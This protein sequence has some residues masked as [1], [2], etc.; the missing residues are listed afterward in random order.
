MYIISLYNRFRGYLKNASLYFISSLASALIGVLLNPLL[1]LNLSPED[2]AILGYYSSFTLLV[3]PLLH[4]CLLSYYSRQYYFIDEN[5]REQLGNTILLS[6]N[7]IGFISLLIFLLL[8]YGFCRITNVEFAFM[9]YAVLTFAQVYISNNLTFYL[10]QLRIQRKAG[11]Y[12][13]VSIANCII[14]NI[15][16]IIFVVVFKGGA[17]GKL[18]AALIASLLVAC[19]SFYK[20]LTKWQLDQHLLKD[21]LNFGLPLTFSALFWYCLSGVDRLFLERLGDISS[22][23][24]Y[25]VAIS[26]AAYMQLIFN[27]LNSTFEPDI[28][29]A[30]AQQNKKKL[31]LIITVILLAVIVSN[32]VFILF[33][34]F[35]VNLLTAGRYIDSVPY[36]RILAIS[37]ITMACYYMVVKLIIGN[38]FVKGELAVRIIGSVLSVLM[39]YFIIKYNGYIGASWGQVISF[40][41]LSIIGILFLFIKM[42]RGR[43]KK[44]ENIDIKV[45]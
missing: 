26:I 17:Q 13:K 15:L 16:I 43:H 2:Y 28:Y 22:L 45:L 27:T 29:Q 4:C 12:A 41:L 31:F 20:S 19:Y 42:C 33:S 44:I 25:N 6:I 8:F 5:K 37:N 18:Y 3:L 10:T 30:I 14:T 11:Q 39:Y 24:T 38:G 32:L 23:G 34:P 36:I 9:P 21:A 1:A 35:I 40:G 7:L